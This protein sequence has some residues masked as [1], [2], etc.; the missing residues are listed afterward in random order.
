MINKLKEKFL[1]K[2]FLTFGIIGVINTVIA[3]LL[4]K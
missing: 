2:Q 1:N 4:N 3:L